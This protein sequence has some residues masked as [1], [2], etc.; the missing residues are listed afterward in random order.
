MPTD[1]DHAIFNAIGELAEQL[2]RASRDVS[3][4]FADPKMM[5]I[6]LYKRLRTNHLGFSV[7]WNQP[8]PIEA[9]IILRSGLEVAICIAANQRK[10]EA[11]VDLVRGD[12]AATLT[13]QIKMHRHDGAMDLVQEGE[14][15][16]RD[17]A[18]SLPE[19]AKPAR[20]DWKSLAEAG[21]VPR[22]YGFYRMLSGVSSHVTG[23]SLMEGVTDDSEE[24]DASQARL[25][26]LNKKMHPMM[27]AGA[28]LTGSLHH[29]LM[30]EDETLHSAAV[31]LS[32]WMA[33]LSKGWPG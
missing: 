32:K 2:W 13:G 19:G 26:D 16:L 17:L 3:G 31:E 29:A 6:M 14:A 4:K 18:A 12:A 10:R 20:L 27:M 33:E 11:F 15:N 28:T 22:L 1:E 30:L 24:M 5:S 7:L 9:A 25:R 21:E 23:L 8:L